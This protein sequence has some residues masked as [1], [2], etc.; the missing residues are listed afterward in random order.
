MRTKCQSDES[1]SKCRIT[2]SNY[3]IDMALRIKKCN[4]CFSFNKIYF[5]VLN[6]L[7]FFF[8]Y[9]CDQIIAEASNSLD[10]FALIISKAVSKIFPCNLFTFSHCARTELIEIFQLK[11]L[12][13][14]FVLHIC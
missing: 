3:H 5:L 12:S 8:F 10:I 11:K 2:H 14:N 6:I 9:V 4:V 13:A 1:R 7:D